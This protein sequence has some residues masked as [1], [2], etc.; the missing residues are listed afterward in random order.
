MP[1]IRIWLHCVW[2]TKNRIT[3]LNEKNKKKIINHIKENATSKNIF[4]DT[5]NGDK[6]HL[7]III[8]LKHDQNIST[9]MQLIKGESSFWINKNKLTKYNFEW[10]DEYFAVSISESLIQKVREYIQNQEEHHKIKTWTEEYNEF[11]NKF[12]YNKMKG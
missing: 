10:A 3:F 12:G 2:G 7:H 4:I 8:S 1:Y 5:I 9:V 11:V 6:E